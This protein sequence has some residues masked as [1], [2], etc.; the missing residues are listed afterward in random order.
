MIDP[1]GDLGPEGARMVAGELYDP[2]APE[3]VRAR[4][5]ARDLCRALNATTDGDA[6]Y[7]TF[8]RASSRLAIRA[9]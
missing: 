5:R 6:E 2:M 4:A 8:R 9:A 1:R 3:L 7:A